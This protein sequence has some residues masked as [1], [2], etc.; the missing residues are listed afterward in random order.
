MLYSTPAKRSSGPA[1]QQSNFR[2]AVIWFR[3]A[4]ELF[5]DVG[6]TRDAELAAGKAMEAESYVGK[7]DVDWGGAK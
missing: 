4:E 2:S 7:K 1:V 6:L 5:T 3:K